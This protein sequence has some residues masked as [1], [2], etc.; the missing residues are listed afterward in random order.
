VLFF[1]ADDERTS[2]VL[3]SSVSDL[4]NTSSQLLRVSDSEDIVS[5]VES[6]ED[7]D[8]FLSLGD[9]VDGI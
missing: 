3:E 7:L 8:S 6:L 1:I 9:G 2:S 4:T 5:D